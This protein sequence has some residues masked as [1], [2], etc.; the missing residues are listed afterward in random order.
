[1]PPAG[2]N[3]TVTELFAMGGYGAFIWPCYG[4]TVVVLLSLLLVSLKGARTREAELERL[5]H[6]R[7]DRAARRGGRPTQEH[8]S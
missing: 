8:A 7:T 3:D 4:L 1:M 5:Q 2:E 6:S